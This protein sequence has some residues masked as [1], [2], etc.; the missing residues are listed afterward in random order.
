M[1]HQ[2][3][4]RTILRLILFLLLLITST[5]CRSLTPAPS[6]A[7]ESIPAP[8]VA[9]SDAVSGIVLSPAA[10][11]ELLAGNDFW[12]PA[13][14]KFPATAAGKKNSKAIEQVVARPPE[15]EFEGIGGGPLKRV[16]FFAAQRAYPLD[17][18]PR[19]GYA[20]AVQQTLEMAAVRPAAQAGLWENI[21]PAPMKNSLMGSQ[22]IDVS[23][24]V[25][26][27]AV[28]P[29]NG[30]VVYLGAA[31]GGVW[32]TTN[33]GDSW[34]PMSDAQASL[35]I[36]AIALDPQ[37]PD[38]VYAGTGE[39]TTG[40][41]NY[42]G[43]GILKST[44]GGQSWTRLGIDTFS[45]LG[46]ASII[47]NPQ[48][49]NIVYV[50]SSISGIDG[51][52]APARGIFRSLDGGQS[53]EAL[54]TCPDCQGASELVID[55]ATP[56]TLY[57]GIYGYGVFKS[58]DGGTNWQL[59]ANGLPNREQVF[60]GRVRLAINT[61]D[62]NV[63]YASMH[64][65]IQNQY[66][67]PA[68][69]KTT[70]GGQSWAV[71]PMGNFNFCGGQ[72]WY[73]HVIA[74][75]PAQPNSLFLG[76]AADYSGET[77]DD[78]VIRR[79]LQRSTDNGQTWID[80]SPGD[81]PNRT[82]HPDMHA[83]SFDPQSPQVIWAG[84][85]GGVFKSVDNGATW[86]NKNSNLAT[87]QFT[88]FDVDI[89]N[90]QNIQGG[91]QD[92]NKAF[93]TNGGTNRAWTATDRGDGGFSLIDPFRS[94]I[95]YG[96]RQNGTFQRN[97]QG[98]GGSNDW[99]IK[100]I[101]LDQQER[102]LFYIPITVDNATEGVLYLGMSRVYRT[103]DR[104]EQWVPI[105]T[106]LSKGQGYVSAI[107]VART[108]PNVLYVGTSDGNLHVSRNSGGSWTN[109][110]KAPLPNRYVSWI[111]VLPTDPNVAYVVYNGFNSHTPGEPGHVF[112]TADG[113]A[114][115]QDISSNL[116]D[117][118]ALTL[119]LDPGRPNT[120]Y[121]GT[122]TG[123]FQT[124]DDG[125]SWAP[126]RDG[127]PNSPVVDLAING[128]WTTLFAATHG[129]SVF[130]LDLGA[131]GIQVTPTPDAPTT[132]PGSNR[133][134]LPLIQKNDGSAQPTATPT[135]P[136]TVTPTPTITPTPIATNTP[137]ATPVPVTPQGTQFP[138]ATPTDQPT[139]TATATETRPPSTSPT[140]T[141]TAAPSLRAFDDDF[142]NPNSG[143]FGET[144][145]ACAFSYDPSTGDGA[146]DNLQEI[147]TINVLTFDEICIS[148]APANAQGDGSYQVDAVSSDGSD[149]SIYGLMFGL[150]S[151]DNIGANSQF[152]VF[153]VNPAGPQY[154]LQKFDRG[155]W[156]DLTGDSA[157]PFVESTAIF[158]GGRV[159]RLKVRRIGDDIL[160]FVNGLALELV[161]DGS[162]P[163]NG[164]VGLANWAA[165][166]TPAAKASF[167]N[168]Q[169]NRYGTVFEDE[170]SRDNSGW[171]IDGSSVCQ[172]DYLGGLYSTAT[173]AD[174]FCLYRSPAAAQRNGLFSA[175]MHDIPSFYETAYGLMLG[176]DGNFGDYYL[177]LIA[178]DS[179]SFALLKHIDGSGFF[180]VTWDSVF[181]TAWLYSGSI[182]SGDAI[183]DLVIERDEDLFRLWINGT[184][185]GA[186]SDP[187]P[188][189]GGYFGVINWASPFENSIVDFDNFSVAAWE[190]GGS[191]VRASSVQT[192]KAHSNALPQEI[193]TLNGVRQ[194]PS[195]GR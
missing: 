149:G 136:P 147:Y 2:L 143:W 80:L 107:A 25:R 116:P 167:D 41:D 121:I 135:V 177:F 134:V 138:T 112:R 170:Y 113:G 5:S 160:L 14:A 123:V 26:A 154:A 62:P 153:W 23:G 100:T 47:V 111:D 194:L 188:L 114:S 129:R 141:A 169:I 68:V 83:I 190:P 53:W 92:N 178:P 3:P 189:S 139:A 81:T 94:Q 130:K 4:N 128:P 101:G 102:R 164:Y 48:N 110:A 165:F 157:G 108:A 54:L 96:T 8:D 61:A 42:Y 79:V 28:D 187:A 12:D 146:S 58:V 70:D 76:G 38:V 18:L 72:C 65:I 186:Y 20:R 158:S 151:P 44:N 195:T 74:T 1:S 179:Q 172:A 127:L 117:I 105:S 11:E 16:N 118:P 176:E 98:A 7:P 57:A 180:G 185:H 91:M 122:D 133:V 45:G 78:L 89:R 46:I 93:T 166:D 142:G 86:Q 9:T 88:G 137:T 126:L 51:P 99:P 161:T 148:A 55:P 40:G 84:N 22:P 21:G 85:D 50:A 140:P 168:L 31:N 33:G 64:I 60:V 6:S 63:V 10:V 13:S 19:G 156:T 15:T 24:R 52:T 97:D 82:L 87:L 171:L 181:E 29:R 120:L 183:N 193:R 73:S 132:N 125:R 159:N 182:N 90:D 109:V 95:W 119:L 77:L 150:D 75:H 36:G 124:Q 174:F 49:P 34:T 106:D 152:Y 56:A 39:P 145:G 71:I 27:L 66:D 144:T 155:T 131:A 59:L 163:N 67:G 17:T 184:F 173:T 35:A 69:F 175:R 43:A 192:P 37:N 32:K 104:G 115:W 191:I 30:D 162:F 103:A